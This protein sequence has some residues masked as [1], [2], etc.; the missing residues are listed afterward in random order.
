M[1]SV[2]KACEGNYTS[3]IADLKKW[4][5]IR[6]QDHEDAIAYCGFLSTDEMQQGA[7]AASCF[8]T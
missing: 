7:Q 8:V 4:S 3:L 2:L 5:S 6:V 1:K